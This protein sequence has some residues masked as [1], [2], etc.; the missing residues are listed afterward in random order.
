MTKREIVRLRGA[1]KICH[2]VLVG[3]PRLDQRWLEAYGGIVRTVDLS[4]R[5]QATLTRVL[6]G[7]TGIARLLGCSATLVLALL[8]VGCSSS[9]PPEDNDTTGVH[10]DIRKR[11]SWAPGT[12]KVF[13]NGVSGVA[14][15][16][17]SPQE[18]DRTIIE[19]YRLP[20]DTR[21]PAAGTGPS[22]DMRL[23]ALLEGGQLLRRLTPGN[24]LEVNDDAFPFMFV[25]EDNG[26]E[27]GVDYSQ[28][29][30]S[31]FF[32]TYAFAYPPDDNSQ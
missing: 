32:N 16:L 18:P 11:M 3:R 29:D 13:E 17:Y 14:Y 4:T 8:V 19:I 9:A 24:T 20:A 2:L 30:Q 28:E 5:S 22:S 21:L 1:G 23:S 6:L 12:Y 27:I 15:L 26:T 25:F 31:R 7:M 10:F